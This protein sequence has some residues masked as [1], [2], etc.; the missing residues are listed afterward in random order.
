MKIKYVVIIFFIFLLHGCFSTH[1]L[2]DFPSKE[3]FYE[4]VNNVFKDKNT[5][6]SLTSDSVIVAGNGISIK[7]NYLIADIISVEKLS[8]KIALGDVSD[9]NYEDKNI[10]GGTIALKNSEKVQAE[11]IIVRHDSIEFIEVKNVPIQ[12]VITC[13]KVKSIKY[14]NRWISILPDAMIGLMSGGAIGYLWGKTDTNDHGE[15]QGVP[16]FLGGAFAGFIG[17]SIAGLFLGFPVT[18]EFNP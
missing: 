11:N 5:R 12:V 3:K 9:L 18:Y 2:A 7:D 10:S 8:R 14:K 4:D 6:I 15:N 1:R 13:D 17:G 16:G